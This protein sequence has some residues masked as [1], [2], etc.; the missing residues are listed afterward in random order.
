MANNIALGIVGKAVLNPGNADPSPAIPANQTWFQLMEGSRY[1]KDPALLPM[2]I[3]QGFP[4][5]SVHSQGIT[6]PA[7]LIRSLLFGG[8]NTSLDWFIP[9]RLQQ[10]L[11]PNASTG[12]IDSSLGAL[13]YWFAD[14]DADGVPVEYSASK[15]ANFRLEWQGED[16]IIATMLMML[17][18]GEKSGTSGGTAVTPISSASGAGTQVF[19]VPFMSQG[20]RYGS[21]ATLD[22][23]ES[24]S[25]SFN[26]R[27]SPEISTP[28]TTQQALDTGVSYPNDYLNDPPIVTLEIVQLK[29]AV[30][31]VEPTDNQVL[32][33]EIAF[34]PLTGAI[35]TSFTLQVQKPIVEKT[36]SRGLAAVRRTYRVVRPALATPSYAIAANAALT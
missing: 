1:V 9:L 25:L 24:G 16:P 5:F 3:A 6:K 13:Q 15:C 14:D 17:Y 11:V 19:G 31:R 22:R 21:S 29:G 10:M 4:D 20:V 32:P 18:G 26:M 8:A 34:R 12:F 35:G 36:F 30:H 33:V 28:L 23:V 27:M 2:E 7:L